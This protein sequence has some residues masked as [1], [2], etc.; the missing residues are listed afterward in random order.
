MNGFLVRNANVITVNRK[1]PQASALVIEEDKIA[2]VGDDK[3]L[4]L[5]ACKGLDVL[6][7]RGFT[8]LPGLIDSHLHLMWMGR[9][10]LYPPLNLSGV[11]SIGKITEIVKEEVAKSAPGQ[12]II[13][14]KLD[15]DNLTDQRSLTRHDLDKISPYNPVVVRK[16]IEHSLVANTAALEKAG[17]DKKTAEPAGGHIEKDSE[18]SP[19]GALF[20][21]AM[22]LVEQVIPRLTASE[23]RKALTLA[24]KQLCS[25]GFTSVVS[26]DDFP[27]FTDPLQ[28]LEDLDAIACEHGWALR[29]T[30]EPDISRIDQLIEQKEQLKK[31]QFGKI[32]PLKIFA[33]GALFTRSAA[34]EED[35]ADEPGN[36]GIECFAKDE[37][38]ELVARANENGFSVAI[39]AIG[40]KAVKNSIS[41]IEKAQQKHFR[42]D[43]RHRIVHCSMIE[44]TNLEKM[45]RLGIIADIQPTF[46]INEWKWVPQ[47]IGEERV[48]TAYRG[49]SFLDN[50]VLSIAGSDA[51][52][53]PADPF[54]SMYG[55]VNRQDVSGKPQGG[56]KP[57][58][59][60]SVSE[61]LHAYT[62]AGAYATFE[63]E[64]KGSLEPG[65]LADFIVVNKNPMEIRPEELLETECLMTVI[66][67]KI[68][69][70]SEDF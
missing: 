54:R 66:G 10:L 20:E 32:G 34:L 24:V 33:D 25:L 8:V 17:I 53:E 37:L 67:G 55:A 26:N 57:E 58:E 14:V 3:D 7:C 9:A 39:H 69:W 40:D 56:W 42:S 15:E 44:R 11:D 43:L 65:K 68:A 36:R 18:G 47:R 5:Y 35:Y 70:R 49:R 27:V 59:K 64:L 46:F 12:W 21:N 51:P 38:E 4:E 62:L 48:K 2:A 19:T 63:E 29:V 52:S 16:A 60:M 13:A 28:L 6:D 45:S 23:E 22:K 31:Y 61:I 50:G 41:A 1:Q 30:F